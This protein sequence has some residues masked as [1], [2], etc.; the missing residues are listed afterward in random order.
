MTTNFSYIVHSN[1]L[2]TLNNKSKKSPK[3]IINQNYF[4]NLSGYYSYDLLYYK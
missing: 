1:T 2:S 4:A 3:P